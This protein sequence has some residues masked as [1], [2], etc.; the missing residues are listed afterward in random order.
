[1]S[2]FVRL[3]SIAGITAGLLAGG[4]TAALAGTPTP[5]P[6][7]TVS[8]N[9]GIHPS[10]CP[11]VTAP[12][13]LPLRPG[14]D[15][16]DCHGIR[17]QEFDI[18]DH[19]FQVRPG[20]FRD[21]TQVLGTGPI[22]FDLGRDVTI[23]PTSD[24][25]SDRFGDSVVIHHA[26]IGAADVTIDRATCSILVSQRDLPW[27]IRGGGTGIDRRAVAAGLYDLSGLVSF[28]TRDFRCTLPVTLTTTQAAEDLNDN[29]NGLPLPLMSDFAVQATGWS[30]LN[31]RGF[32][33]VFAPVGS[34]S[35]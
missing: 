26:A 18:S 28:P 22:R 25:L 4:A 13:P 20:I 11:V 16:R 35:A 32:P 29:G 30:T 7:S 1:M 17:Q 9:F 10:P 15:L 33:H 12:V 31:L 27:W 21:Q 34:P 19:G 23:D 14:V 5:S 24:Q 8:P 3:A 6:S 2:K